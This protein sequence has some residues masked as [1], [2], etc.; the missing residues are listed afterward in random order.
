MRV[1]IAHTSARV[2]RRITIVLKE[3]IPIP[4]PI[5]IAI[6][7]ALALA[8]VGG[9][10]VVVAVVVIVALICFGPTQRALTKRLGFSLGR[11]HLASHARQR[12]IV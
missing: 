10:A 9:I 8:V 5:A 11:N 12:P 4:I 6:A 7:L 2:A 1:A 3:A